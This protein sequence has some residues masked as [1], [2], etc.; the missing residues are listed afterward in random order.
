MDTIIKK[1]KKRLE[2]QFQTCQCP[3]YECGENQRCS[4]CGHGDVWHKLSYVIKKTTYKKCV[5]ENCDDC[6]A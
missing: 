6:P 1:K 5:E 2:C 4:Y 3:L